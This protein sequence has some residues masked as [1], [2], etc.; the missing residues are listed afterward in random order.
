MFKMVTE[1]YYN[2]H[3]QNMYFPLSFCITL[4]HHAI[5]MGNLIMVFSANFVINRVSVLES[6]FLVIY[7]SLM[8]S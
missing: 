4:P 1:L 2:T 8:S 7:L 3:K 6:F 5:I